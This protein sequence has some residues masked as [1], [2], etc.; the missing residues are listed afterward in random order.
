MQPPAINTEMGFNQ[1]IPTLNEDLLSFESFVEWL[2]E[3]K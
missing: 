2:R 1:F 3:P